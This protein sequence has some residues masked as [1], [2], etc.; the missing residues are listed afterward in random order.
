MDATCPLEQRVEDLLSR[1]TLEEKAGLMFHAPIFMNEDGTFVDG[2]V[3]RIAEL[4]L[5]HFN[6]YV[7]PPPRQQ[8]EWHNRLQ[9]VA[10]LNPARH[11]GDDLVRPAPR[12]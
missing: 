6:I 5:N 9:D 12:V 2:T 10:L 3:E 7:A 11:P 1:M 4:H 8:A